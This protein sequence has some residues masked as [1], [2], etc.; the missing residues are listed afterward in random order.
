M[1]QQNEAI[2]LKIHILG[3]GKD[4]TGKHGKLLKRQKK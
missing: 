4:M 3:G 2:Q 1:I